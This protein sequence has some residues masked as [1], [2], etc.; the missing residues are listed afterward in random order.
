VKEMVQRFK[1]APESANFCDILI[2]SYVGIG[3]AKSNNRLVVVLEFADIDPSLKQAISNP[4]SSLQDRLQRM[5]H[6]DRYSAKDIAPVVL[7]LAEREQFEGNAAQERQ[8][9][10]ETLDQY[11]HLTASESHTMTN[12][13]WRLVEKAVQE[14]KIEQQDFDW[15]TRFAA[16]YGQKPN[17]TVIGFEEQV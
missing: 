2:H 10:S 5:Q 9:I 7:D 13:L 1:E 4:L 12:K 6:S 8:H 17:N 3:V 11:E 16:L 14:P 15:I